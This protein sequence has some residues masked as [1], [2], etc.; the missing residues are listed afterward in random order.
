MDEAS[1]RT[2]GR[3]SLAAE[4]VTSVFSLS[5]MA[6]DGLEE[7]SGFPLILSLAESV[8]PG[9]ETLERFLAERR[10]RFTFLDELGLFDAHGRVVVTSSS[11]FPRGY[12][13]GGLAHYR[14]FREDP[15]LQEWVTGLYWSSFARDFRIIHVRRLES[16]SEFPAKLAATMLTPQLFDDALARLP[17]ARGESLALLDADHQL[18]ARR[19]GCIEPSSCAAIGETVESPLSSDGITEGLHQREGRAMSPLDGVER[20]YAT[21]P[22]EGR[23]FVVTA[24]ESVAVLLEGWW[25]QLWVRGSILLLVI[26]M[27]AALLRHYLSRLRLD[28]EARIAA[29]AFES[30]QGMVVTDARGRI[31]RVNQA[32]VRIT[33]YSERELLGRNPSMLSSG[34]HDETFYRQMWQ[35]IH[36]AGSW[37][38][39]VWN[40][41][42]NGELYPECLLISAVT[43]SDGRVT[44]Y[45]GALHD[46]SRQKAA[47]DEA[48]QLAF[49][50][51]LT[52]L[53][54]RRYL[55]DMLTG[56]ADGA[57]PG[58]HFGAL[59]LVDLD[60]FKRVN[61]LIGH[62]QGDE[63][64]RR[65][66]LE[67]QHPLRDT[68]TVARLSGDEFAVLLAGLSPD[69]EHAAYIAERIATELIKALQLDLPGEQHAVQVSASI[70]VTLFQIRQAKPQYIMQQADIALQ[71]AKGEGRNRFCFFDSSLQEQMRGRLRLEADL[72]EA[73]PK[74]QFRLYFQRQMDAA[75]VILGAEVLLRWEHHERGMVSPAEFIPLAEENRQIIAIDHWVLEAACCQLEVWAR[76]SE[77]RALTLAVNISTLQFKETDFVNQVRQILKRTGAPPERLKI[78][79]T[80]GMFL[81]NPEEASEKMQALKA[82]GL[83]FALDDF[84]TGFSSLSYLNRLPLDQLKIDQSFV[85]EVL[86]DPAS[87]S[88]VAS[89]IALAHSLELEVIAEGVET[90]AQKNWL[91]VHDCQRFQGYLFGR[92]Q[93]L[94]EFEKAIT[95]ALLF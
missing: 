19:P 74:S 30:Q 59:L 76:R 92:P 45:V 44:H 51:P 2:F 56:L 13:L 29:T 77:T 69:Q 33:G 14:I 15:A 83:T 81:E 58:G 84:G 67:L 16:G 18:V 32:F 86:D 88:I 24:G 5:D 85:R 72:R 89:T 41:R 87:A 9:Y 50:D 60:H 40:R 55:L 71:Q 80:E 57:R 8:D 12:D 52:G 25:Q 49:F 53:P 61:D 22:V 39:E 20:L 95:D 93:P 28:Q 7:V 6:L 73:L 82:L 10:D 47:E 78:E 21:V 17:M 79:V 46:I 64:L 34:R 36:Q 27:G 91:V 94:A 38:G 43:G 23:P 54:N 70:G 68:D 37:E 1:E 75:G 63:L 11:L 4:W 66:T 42:R 31:L 62:H 48:L 35:S 90:E 3:A 26:L 65:I